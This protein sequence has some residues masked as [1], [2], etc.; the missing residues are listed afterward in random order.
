[1]VP[2]TTLQLDPRSPVPL[3]RQLYAELRAAVL[4]GRVSRGARLPSTRALAADLDV[5]RNT[6]A[7]AFDQLLAEGYVEARVGSG[8]YI[9]SALPDDLLRAADPPRPAPSAPPPELKLSARGRMLASI[10][11]SPSPGSAEPRAFRP[12]IPALDAFPR[13]LWARIAARHIRHARTALMSYS[14]AAGL[15][16]LRSAIAEYLRAARGVRCSAEQVVVTAG[17]QQAIDLAARVLLDPGDG[18]W[19]EDPG[20]Q[21]ARG[22]LLA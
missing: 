22:A 9:A 5:S 11:V 21:G 16:P 17:S 4:A 18:V 13:D 19:M 3:H 8:T 6:V 15:P 2:F 1:M 7:A 12:G 14:S 10:A 20:Y